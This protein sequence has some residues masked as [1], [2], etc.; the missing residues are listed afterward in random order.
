M[1]SATQA[2]SATVS[3]INGINTKQQLVL[4]ELNKPPSTTQLM[5]KE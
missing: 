4:M 5:T 2:A 1:S 3:E